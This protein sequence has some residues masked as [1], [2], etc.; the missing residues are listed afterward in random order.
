ML[1][2]KPGPAKSALCH[3]EPDRIEIRG[4]DLCRDLMGERSFTEFFYML[5]TGS[6]PTPEQRFFL[7]VLLIAIAEHGLTPTAVA[8]R[9]TYD[10]APESLQSALAAGILGCG[11]VVLGTSELCG[12]V[13]VDARER[14]DRGADPD[15]VVRAIA[16]EVRERGGKMPGF[17]HPIHRPT[18]PRT[19][20]IFE[21]TD[22]KGVSGRYTDLARRFEPAVAEVWGRPLTMNVS[23]PIAACLLDL[24][25]PPD[26]DQGDPAAGPH[27]RAARPSRRGAG[28]A[29][30][31]PDGLEGRG[32]DIL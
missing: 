18:D 21:L 14:I 16:P 2:G 26:D 13:L 5:M 8:A 11:T 4:R 19:D 15:A 24:D 10:A 31:L 6:D 12:A 27:R 17:G 1:I 28:A 9:M 32:S 29:D 22:R 23:M 7:D 3:A 20:R 25:F 30:R